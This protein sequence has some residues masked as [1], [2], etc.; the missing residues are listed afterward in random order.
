[1]IVS[2]VSLASRLN[3]GVAHEGLSG[4]RQDLYLPNGDVVKGGIV[5][6][7]YIKLQNINLKTMGSKGMG[8]SILPCSVM[9]Y[10][11]KSVMIYIDKLSFVTTFVT[12]I[13]MRWPQALSAL[14]LVLKTNMI[15]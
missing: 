1:M 9:R 10:H 11:P 13:L 15:C 8:V 4:E 14:E 5:E 2:P 6:V 3:M 7:A 12:N